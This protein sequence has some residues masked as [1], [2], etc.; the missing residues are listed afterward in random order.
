MDFINRLIERKPELRLGN[1][2]GIKELKE[3]FFL[4][5]Y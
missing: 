2:N 3:H 5:F 4:R 1:K